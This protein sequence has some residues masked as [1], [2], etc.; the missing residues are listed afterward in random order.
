MQHPHKSRNKLTPFTVTRQIVPSSIREAV[1]SSYC[2]HNDAEE[3]T[4]KLELKHSERLCYILKF[5]LKHLEEIITI[6]LDEV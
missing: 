1:V 6:M 2:S 4:M 3:D 5:K